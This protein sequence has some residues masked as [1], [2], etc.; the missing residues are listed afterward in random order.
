MPFEKMIYLYSRQNKYFLLENLK[1][2]LISVK[3][4]GK[5]F[6]I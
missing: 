4:R 2:K 1:N 5:D 6:D 3:L